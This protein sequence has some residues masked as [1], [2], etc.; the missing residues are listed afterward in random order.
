MKEK[1]GIIIKLE[2]IKSKILDFIH[3]ETG[4]ASPLQPRV[5]FEELQIL[6]QEILEKGR[7][8]VSF[9]YIFD[10]D[11]FSMYDKRHILEGIIVFDE[12]GKIIE[13]TLDETRTGEAANLEPY[14]SNK[15]QEKKE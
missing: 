5:S 4:Y 2:K 15:K 7:I 3:E 11:G 14:K 8:Q 6:D 12:T 9:K 10:E 1:T 13:W